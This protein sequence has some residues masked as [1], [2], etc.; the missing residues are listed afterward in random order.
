MK[1]VLAFTAVCL[2]WSFSWFAVKIQTTSSV[3]IS[4]SIFYRFLCTALILLPILFLIGKKI[5]INISELKTFV[6]LGFVNAY[7]NFYFIYI[8]CDY[9]P[10]GIIAT[11]SVTTIF[12][13]EFA[14]CLYEKRR[15]NLVI[16]LTSITGA[17]GMLLMFW[18]NISNQNFELTRFIIGVLLCL[19]SNIALSSN[20]IL[21]SIN[22]KKNHS[23]PFVS[24]GYSCL[25][26]AFFLFAFNLIFG[27]SIVFDFS[28]KYAGSLFY[29]VVFASIIAYSSVYY[30]NTTVGPSK[31]GYTALV[32]T[33][34]SMIIS[35][36]FEGW[37]W[38][39][40]GTIG[41][42]IILVSVVFGLK[43]KEKKI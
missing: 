19:V 12:F 29:L 5:K 3:Y 42:A 38:H 31:T 20:Y 28:Y 26:A 23:S 33:P 41:I 18:Y 24:L 14:M 7:F 1:S 6:L 43:A 25:F 34:S 10:S 9:I 4:V 11:L 16:L 17:I 30:L 35:T 40:T 39:F 37:E 36:L 22:S 15:P 21:I 2:S 32:Y 13:S 27:H 8:A